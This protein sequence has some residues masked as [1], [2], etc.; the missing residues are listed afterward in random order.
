MFIK[1]HVLDVFDKQNL[2]KSGTL[3]QRAINMAKLAGE[4]IKRQFFCLNFVYLYV[5][6]VTKILTNK[7]FVYYYI[8]IDTHNN[9]FT[10]SFK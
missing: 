4:D 3:L 7:E 5:Q 2:S 10:E 1:L 8:N 6:D 9:N